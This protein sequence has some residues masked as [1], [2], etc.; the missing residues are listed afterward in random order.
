V[1]P[2]ATKSCPE[3]VMPN[4]D[5][6]GYYRFSLDAAG[7]AALQANFAR[8]NER[9]QR[10]F[11]DSIT[12]AYTAGAIDTPAFLRAA[13]DLSQAPLASTALAPV[14]RIGWLIDRVAVSEK[15]KQALR[16][17]LRAW[18]APRLAALGTQPR[19]GESDEV[20]LLRS[21]LINTLATTA[22]DPALR[23]TLVAQG[24]AVLG[25]S[26]ADGQPGDGLLH[27]DAA[28]VEERGLALSLAMELGDAQV[29]DALLRHFEASQDPALRRQLLGA[30][31]NA[32]QPALAA[33]ARD[34]AL[35][36]STVR[37]NELGSLISLDSG[38]P[39][40]WP[41]ARAW[42]DGNYPALAAKL[43]AGASGIAR[44]YASNM[45]S[46]AEAT[47]MTAQW[48]ERMRA[49]DGGPRALAQTAESINLCAALK[50]R[51]AEGL[52]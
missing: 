47:A 1:V 30:V 4:A 12:A 5:G 20:R 29:F 52:N 39:A 46:P 45:C 41:A 38:S 49:V 26:T 27:P 44:L 3:F 19:D 25:L 10:V 18:Y 34:Y 2:L 8:L 14:S 37:R 31:G 16:D 21:G 13:A 33:R 22:R 40:S 32:K 28:S 9:E 15:Q 48:S 42:L 51:H 23:A 36:S 17:R 11:A 7:Q 6:A 24:R 43:G 35:A 50:A